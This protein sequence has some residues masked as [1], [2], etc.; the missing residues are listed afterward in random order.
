MIENIVMTSA[1]DSFGE[2]STT[3]DTDGDYYD[4]VVDLNGEQIGEAARDFIRNN[5]AITPVRD[6]FNDA[7]CSLIA[8]RVLGQDRFRDLRDSYFICGDCLCNRVLGSDT[9]MT[10]RDLVTQRFEAAWTRY[11]RYFYILLYYTCILSLNL[12]IIR[13]ENAHNPLR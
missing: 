2:I 3:P 1:M 13:L 7:V 8:S 11:Y 10:L 6:R 4:D 12:K 5:T 9:D